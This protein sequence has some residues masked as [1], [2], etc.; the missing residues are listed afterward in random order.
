MAEQLHAAF[1]NL[2]VKAAAPDDAPPSNV[3]VAGEGEIH[4]ARIETDPNVAGGMWFW[5]VAD[6]LRVAA[7]NAVRIAEELVAKSSK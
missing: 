1:A 3:S 7:T 6:N 5:G 4:L 2:G